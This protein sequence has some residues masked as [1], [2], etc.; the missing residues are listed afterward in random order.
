MEPR[1]RV[2]QRWTQANRTR[3]EPVDVAKPFNIPKKLVWEAYLRVKA[4]GGGPRY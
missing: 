2:V 1:G 4:S 3:E